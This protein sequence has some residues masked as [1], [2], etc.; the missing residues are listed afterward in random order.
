MRE[1]AFITQEIGSI[2]R[3][4]WRQKLDAK[5][6]P[7]WIGEVIFWGERLGVKEKSELANPKKTGLLQKS[8]RTP[9]EKQRIID[10]ASLY[11]I[12]MFESAGLD[13]VFNGEQPRT[14]MYDFLAKNTRGI[15]TAGV[16]NSFD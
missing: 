2:Q 15:S 11:V 1:K 6:L 8:A 5:P 14:E 4:A 9:A 7:E 10:I 13:R 16:L 3:P 12:R